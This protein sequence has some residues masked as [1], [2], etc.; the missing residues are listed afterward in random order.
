MGRVDDIAKR[1]S[2]AGVLDEDRQ[3]KQRFPVEEIE[4]AAIEDHPANVAVFDTIFI[5]RMSKIV[6]HQ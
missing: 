3:A 1:F 2:L 5:A 4:V 6:F